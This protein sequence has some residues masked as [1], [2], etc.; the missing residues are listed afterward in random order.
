M[1]TIPLVQLISKPSRGTSA[2]TGNNTFKRFIQACDPPYEASDCS[3]QNREC[4]AKQ[5]SQLI[6]RSVL[7]GNGQE[8]KI[9]DHKVR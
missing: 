8:L 2:T 5:N 9:F 7:A 1:D 6:T 3:H 4:E